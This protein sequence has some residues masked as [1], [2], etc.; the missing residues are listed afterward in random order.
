[1]AD[2]GF[3]DTQLMQYLEHHL[4]WHYRIRVKN[5]LWVLRPGKVPCQL[6][7][8]HLNLGDATLL[9]G[10]KITKTN[11]YGLVNLALARDSV[12]GELWHIVSDEPTSLQTFREYSE[13]FDIE[14][15]FLDEKSN[16]FQLEKSLIRSPMAVSR[17]CLVM[18]ITTL[19]LTVQGQ[20]VVRHW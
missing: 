17:L 18:A 11:P 20:E 5:D 4:G 3:A 10:V 9:Q 16:G 6:R 15:E 8:F 2:R 14:E 1:M 7:D 12:S 13:R 19:F